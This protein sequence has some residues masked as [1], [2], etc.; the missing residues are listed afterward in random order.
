[1]GIE[2]PPELGWVVEIAAGQSW[3]QADEDKL[4]EQG[5]VWYD[6]QSRSAWSC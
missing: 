3:P 6:A 2:I 4:S 5:D 1:M